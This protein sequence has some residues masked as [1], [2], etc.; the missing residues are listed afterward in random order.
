[1]PSIFF[2]PERI[3]QCQQHWHCHWQPVDEKNDP[4]LLITLQHKYS[5]PAS[6][7]ILLFITV[8]IGPVAFDIAEHVVASRWPSFSIF[9]RALRYLLDVPSATLFTQH[10]LRQPNNF[11]PPQGHINGQQFFQNTRRRSLYRYGLF[12]ERI[13]QAPHHHQGE[14]ARYGQRFAYWQAA[15]RRLPAVKLIGPFIIGARII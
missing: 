7:T 6:L 15:T 8:Q 11:C 1:M 14:G 3:P 12:D 5:M 13:A 2:L 10:A 4:A 9:V